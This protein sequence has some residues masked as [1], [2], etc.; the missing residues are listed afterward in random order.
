MKPEELVLR[1]IH[2]P[3]A[4]SWWPLAWGWWVLIV[5]LLMLVGLGAWFWYQRQQRLSAV[6][7]ALKELDQYEQQWTDDPQRLLQAVSGLLRR[8]AMTYHPRKTV[9]GLTG[10]QWVTFLN[11]STAKPLFQD[12]HW[13]TTLTQQPYRSGY[14]EHMSNLVKQARSW[15]QQQGKAKKEQ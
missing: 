6:Q 10:Q 1:D 14:S 13:Q 3:E 2:L 15:I 11:Q 9:A 12:T 8:V 4:I 5:L 7:Q